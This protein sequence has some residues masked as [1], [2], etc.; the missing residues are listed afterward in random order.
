MPEPLLGIH[1][2]GTGRTETIAQDNEPDLSA[3]CAKVRA[4]L[5]AFLDAEPSTERLRKVQE[6]TRLSVKICN[7]ALD[8]FR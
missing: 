4:R 7:E 3:L 8:R 2:D 1:S 6:Q 5:G